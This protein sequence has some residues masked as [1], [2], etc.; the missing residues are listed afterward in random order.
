MRKLM[1]GEPRRKNSLCKA[2]Y[3]CED[4][5]HLNW[6]VEEMNFSESDRV[7]GKSDVLSQFGIFML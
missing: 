3:G 5:R 6:T 1:V 4:G 7:N 2:R